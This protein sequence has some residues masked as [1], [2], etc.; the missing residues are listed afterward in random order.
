MG[1]LR[2][3][4]LIEALAWLTIAAVFLFIPMNSIKKL[5]YI[6]LVQPL[7]RGPSY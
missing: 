1:K 7:G 3:V 4:H 6:N 5:K 2:S